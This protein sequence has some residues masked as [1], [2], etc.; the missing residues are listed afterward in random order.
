MN[1][2]FTVT[3]DVED[4]LKK[5]VRVNA[6]PPLG[7]MMNLGRQGTFKVKEI[8]FAGTGEDSPLEIV[9]RCVPVLSF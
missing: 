9:L 4:V 1:S 8:E 3:V 6:L 2:G 7:A 5:E